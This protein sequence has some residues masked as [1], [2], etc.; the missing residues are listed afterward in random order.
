V[1]Q[2]RRRQSKACTHNL[3]LA[4]RFTISRQVPALCCSQGRRSLCDRGDTCPPMFGAV[5]HYHKYSSIIWGVKS[6]RVVFIPILFSYQLQLTDF[7][8]H[9]DKC[10][11]II[12]PKRTFCFIWCWA[13]PRSCR[14]EPLDPT[15]DF[16]LP[17]PLLCH[18]SPPF[19]QIDIIGAMMTFCGVKP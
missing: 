11:V 18:V 14:A 19:P 15:G 8:S 13:S 1:S 12:S 6:S 17:N 4:R 9:S 16:C 5:G 7:S 2:N 3:V 10:Y